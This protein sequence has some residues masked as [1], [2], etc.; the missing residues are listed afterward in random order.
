MFFYY[1]KRWLTPFHN[2]TAQAVLRALEEN[3]MTDEINQ[4]TCD[5]RKEDPIA[6]K[7]DLR[8]IDKEE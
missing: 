6:A 1:K 8:N 7:A 4:W 2:T 5:D 3:P